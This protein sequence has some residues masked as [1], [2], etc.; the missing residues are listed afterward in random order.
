MTLASFLIGIVG[1]LAAKIIVALGLTLVVVTGAVFAVAELKTMALT[2]LSGLPQ[3]VLLLAGL[4]G[5][6]ESL[7]IIFGCITFKI[8]YGVSQN[9]VSVAAAQ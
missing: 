4:F 3:D 5:V 1:A 9:F 8:S 7:G 6:W 2:A